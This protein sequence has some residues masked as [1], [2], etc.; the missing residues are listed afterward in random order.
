MIA[1]V[2][3]GRADLDVHVVDP[4]GG[5]AWSDDPNTYVPPRPGDP[6]DPP[7]A[8]RD[9]GIL[10]HDGNKD[11]RRDANPAEH[12]IWTVEPPAGEYV[13][14]VDARAMCGDA[15]AAWFVAAYRNGELIG[16]ARGVAIPDDTLLPHG[17]GAGGRA[18]RFAL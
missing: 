6:P 3:H 1:L 11:C 10:D 2:W 17:A 4:L 18:L 16:A 12:V 15:S 5:E 7:D 14:R 9:H 13:V 8:W